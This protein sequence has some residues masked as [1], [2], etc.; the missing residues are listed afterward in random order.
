MGRVVVAVASADGD[1]SDKETLV[2]FEQLDV[3]HIFHLAGKTFVPDSWDNPYAFFQTNV[4]GTVNVL[5]FC[6]RT[7]T[8]LTYVSAYVY[9]HPDTL[10]I[11][12]DSVARPNN[13]YAMTK[14]LAEEACEFYASTYGITVTTIRPFNVYGIGQAEAFLIPSIIRQALSNLNRIILK[15]L[16]PKRDYVYL[17]DLLRAIIA[18]VAK[19][20]GYRIYNIGSGVSLSVQDVVD[21]VQKIIGSNK[22]IICDNVIRPNELLNV[23]A[24]ISKAKEELG[25]YPEYSFEK[26][27]EKIIDSK[28]VNDC[29]N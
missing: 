11:R 5:E 6:R 13:P 23:V 22:D 4:L 1:I 26:G 25:W 3:A 7:L 9:G 14:R 2:A 15:D 18:T 28:R 20:D 17:D 16:A 8:P 24:D 12:E 19:S 21:A 10:P 29:E 27:I